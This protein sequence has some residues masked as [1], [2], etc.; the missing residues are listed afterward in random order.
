MQALYSHPTTS[1]DEVE[2][3]SVMDASCG[4]DEV[5]ALENDTYAMEETSSL[6]SGDVSGH[7]ASTSGQA[8]QANQ[9][10]ASMLFFC[11]F[12]SEPAPW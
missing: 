2:E 4:S 6:V 11:A 8:M 3:A 1:D 10:V 7:V 9:Q 12:L 5:D